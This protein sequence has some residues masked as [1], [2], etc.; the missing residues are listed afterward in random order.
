MARKPSCGPEHLLRITQFDRIVRFALIIRIAQFFRFEEPDDIGGIEKRSFKRVEKQ[1]FRD[2][3]Q[4]VRHSLAD[5]GHGIPHKKFVITCTL[6][7]HRLPFILEQGY[8]QQLQ[9][10]C[11]RYSAIQQIFRTGLRQFRHF[12]IVQQQQ[13]IRQEQEQH[14]QQGAVTKQDTVVQQQ[15]EFELQQEY[16]VFQLQQAFIRLFRRIPR[17]RFVRFRLPE[18]IRPAALNNGK[19]LLD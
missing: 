17:Q 12:R 11:I 2:S 4:N 6:H 3:V 16:A 7:R 13:F 19:L 18:K 15:Q 1:G 5:L 8:R 9:K 14:L 10:T